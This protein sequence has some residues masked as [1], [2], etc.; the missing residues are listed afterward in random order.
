MV[1]T[2]LLQV[3]LCNVT[4]YY[5]TVL[6][7]GRSSRCLKGNIVQFSFDICTCVLRKNL[8]LTHINYEALINFDIGAEKYPKYQWAD[9]KQLHLIGQVKH[10]ETIV[11][12]IAMY[13]HPWSK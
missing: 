13:C 12:T 7:G 2:N 5:E 6:F 8:D 9:V 10:C 4:L 3:R 11:K 1:L